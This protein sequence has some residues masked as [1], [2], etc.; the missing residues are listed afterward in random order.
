MISCSFLSY[1]TKLH[2]YKRRHDIS[3]VYVS[4]LFP[5]RICELFPVNSALF[6]SERTFVARSVNT[7]P[8]LGPGSFSGLW[9]ESLY[10]IHF[11]PYG[12]LLS[13]SQHLERRKT[14]G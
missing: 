1:P 10:R 14:I 2:L 7:G 13:A 4:L 8:L 9:N 6:N 12:R 3:T 11:K 5:V